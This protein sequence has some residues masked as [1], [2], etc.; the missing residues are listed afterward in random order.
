MQCVVLLIRARANNK[1][2]FCGSKRARKWAETLATQENEENIVGL[3]RGVLDSPGE[4]VPDRILEQ[5]V[6]FPVSFGEAGSSG[7]GADDATG[8]AATSVRQF[9]DEVPPPGDRK[10]QCLEGGSVFAVSSGEAGSFGPRENDTTSVVAT[11]VAKSVEG[12]R[13]PGVE[14]YR[15]TTGSELAESSSKFPVEVGEARLP[16]VEKVQGYDMIRTRRVFW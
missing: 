1:V 3:G 6:E 5:T 16:G 4:C 12:A 11:V 2:F 13:P 7:L 15:A 9:A 14:K 8:A 10:A